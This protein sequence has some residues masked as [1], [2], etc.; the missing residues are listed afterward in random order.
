MFK[1]STK[2]RLFESFFTTVFTIALYITILKIQHIP[3]YTLLLALECIL[4]AIIIRVFEENKE[5]RKYIFLIL[6]L[7]FFAILF[8]GNGLIMVFAREMIFLLILG[9]VSLLF[10]KWYLNK[11]KKI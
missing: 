4:I 2:K 11:V 1:Q 8:W 7:S 9:T 10:S 5:S 6:L 3:I